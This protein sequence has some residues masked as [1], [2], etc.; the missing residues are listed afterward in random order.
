M[1]KGAKIALFM[2]AASLGNVLV[3]GAIFVVCLG[4]YSLTLARVLPQEAVIWAIGGS[5]LI[6]LIGSIL[7]YKRAIRFVRGRFDLDSWLGFSAKK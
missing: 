7:V 6:S 2:L 5:F 1:S 4:L 3:T